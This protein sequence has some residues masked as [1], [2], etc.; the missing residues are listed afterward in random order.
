[1]IVH[2]G[3]LLI[4]KHQELYRTEVDNYYKQEKQEKSDEVEQN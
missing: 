3:E 2:E 1:M 4:W